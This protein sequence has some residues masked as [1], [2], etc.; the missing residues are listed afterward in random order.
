MNNFIIAYSGDEKYKFCKINSSLKCLD[1]IVNNVTFHDYFDE[2]GNL[3]DIVPN[4]ATLDF[5]GNFI[6]S[7]DANY[8]IAILKPINMTLYTVSVPQ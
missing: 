5:R 2:T 3:L 7:A 6:A 1:G 4:G 8:T